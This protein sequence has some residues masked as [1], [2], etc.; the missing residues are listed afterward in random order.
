LISSIYY[1]IDIQKNIDQIYLNVE[2]DFI[3]F[4]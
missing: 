4:M 3:K 1:T 2:K